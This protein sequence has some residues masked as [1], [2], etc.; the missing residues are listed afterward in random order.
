MDFENLFQHPDH[1]N[2]VCVNLALVFVCRVL[3]SYTEHGLQ[4]VHQT[5][6]KAL[7]GKS[8]YTGTCGNRP[9]RWCQPC[10]GWQKHLQRHCPK[11]TIDWTTQTTANWEESFENIASVFTT[12][13]TDGSPVN[14]L[15]LSNA[16]SIWERCNAFKIRKFVID[17]VREC[18]NK[19]FA[20]NE[21]LLVDENDK[22]KVFD[23]LRDLLNDR[24][25]ES[26]I[27]KTYCIDKLEDIK[28]T[29]CLL[30]IIS[31]IKK[32]F[33]AQSERTIENIRQTTEMGS[34]NCEILKEI[35]YELIKITQKQTRDNLEV[36]HNL[37]I[38]RNKSKSV[39]RRNSIIAA[40][41]TSF[42]IYFIFQHILGNNKPVWNDKSSNN[43]YNYIHAERHAFTDSES[44]IDEWRQEVQEWSISFYKW[45]N[46]CITKP[47]A[48]VSKEI[49]TLKFDYMYVKLNLFDKWNEI[50]YQ[51]KKCPKHFFDIP[52]F[53]VKDE[54]ECNRTE[55]R[56]KLLRL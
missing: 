31:N 43:I 17:N 14:Y 13:P 48:P 6:K 24:D 30:S 41:A 19:Y 8:Q 12:F 49:M 33:D 18:R 16:C 40:I 29:P 26:H 15:D 35:Q 2:Y 42:F 32:N 39:E 7:A 36:I 10:K 20:H 55:I 28:N 52:E 34:E 37:K 3:K 23:A 50:Y 46:E 27:N 21:T 25:V 45:R 56:N 1:E 4:Q 11:H 38:I 54:W 22:A 47:T 9:S 44:I 53:C 51:W 5:I